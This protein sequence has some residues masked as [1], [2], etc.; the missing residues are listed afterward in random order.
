MKRIGTI[1]AGLV[2]ALCTFTAVTGCHKT[3]PPA[4]AI[5]APER[6]VGDII[7]SANS[8]VV[9][10]E[11]DVT[12]GKE[13]TKNPQLKAAM[14]SI[15]KSLTVAQPSYVVWDA[16]LKANPNAPEPANLVGAI[17]AIQTLLGQLPSLTK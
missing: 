6:T 5:T 9:K 13:Y 1:C 14:K 3:T 8:A 4:W 7:Y 15:Q 12:A 17:S 2:L 16:A 11:A 10:Y